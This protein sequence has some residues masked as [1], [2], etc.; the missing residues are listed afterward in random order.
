M[1]NKSEEKLYQNT[2]NEKI[3]TEGIG[4]HTGNKVSMKI[5]VSKL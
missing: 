2:I 1:K 5:L 3:G 4:L